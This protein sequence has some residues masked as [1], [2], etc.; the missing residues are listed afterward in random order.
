MGNCG[1]GSV[2]QHPQYHPQHH[3]ADPLASTGGVRKSSDLHENGAF[4]SV[5]GNVMITSPALERVETGV[6][7]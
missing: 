7:N 1:E 2:F 4:A 6:I 3:S 5:D